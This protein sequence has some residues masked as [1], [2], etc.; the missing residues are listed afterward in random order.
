M[1]LF[2]FLQC[3]TQETV[4]SYKSDTLKIKQLTPN[5][6]IHT[7]YLQ[8]ESYG[9]V[10]CNGLIYIQGNEAIVFDT[11]TH[12]SV[13]R[14]LMTWLADELSCRVKSVVVGHFHEDCLGGL[15]AFHENGANSYANKLTL[16]LAEVDSSSLPQHGFEGNL[17][18][19]L[20]HT[21]VNCTFLGE[22][23]TRDNI[24]SYIPNEK[25]LFGG[26]LIKSMNAGKGY[27]ADGNV[28]E[29]SNTV[30]NVKDTF[31]GVKY[32]VPGHGKVGG[33]EL[34]DFTIELFQQE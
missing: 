13:S 11:P 20:G 19:T 26:C 27:V 12:D 4:Q 30:R 18:L 29:W 15:A 34:L 28:A 16:E 25:V 24:V 1:S 7:S 22:G 3:T 10:P 6:F 8:T 14:E 31:S 33:I 21:E 2:L 17:I 23:H 32:V 9:N 5:T